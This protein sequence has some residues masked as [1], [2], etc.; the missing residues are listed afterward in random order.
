MK[1]VCLLMGLLL[2]ACSSTPGGGT[3]SSSSSGSA[4]LDAAITD[5]N[6]NT[7]ATTANPRACGAELCAIHEVCIRTPDTSVCAPRCSADA[8]CGAGEACRPVTGDGGSNVC[9]A[10]GG[11]GDV[12][13][14]APCLDGLLCART[15]D[16][17]PRCRYSCGALDDAGVAAMCP[18]DWVCF[19]FPDASAGACLPR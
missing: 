12:C 16:G 11:V 18:S 15:D 14:P 7:D 17:G 2:G 10:A 3:S 1:R 6:G 8:G 5:A 9:V 13:S 4:G 19:P